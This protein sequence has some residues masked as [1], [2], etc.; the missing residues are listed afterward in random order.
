[1][2]YGGDLIVATTNGE[3][4][5]V[6]SAGVPTFLANVHAF[7]EG[8]TTVPNDPAR[9]G[10]LAGKVVATWEDGSR[11]GPYPVDP[12]GPP[13]FFG[14]GLSELEDIRVIPPDQNFFGVNF[15]TGRILGVSSTQFTSVVGDLLLTQEFHPGGTPGLYRLFWD[16]TAI[17]VQ[18]FD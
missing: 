13:P 16:G 2:V 10:P 9:Y 15:G 17:R 4:W 5:R 6:T 3:V 11:G 18:P 1:G 8:V 12:Q 7:L 14:L